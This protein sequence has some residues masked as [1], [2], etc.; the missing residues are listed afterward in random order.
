[1]KHGG[2]ENNRLI[3]CNL[4]Y[5]YQC[6]KAVNYCSVYYE[7]HGSIQNIGIND[8]F[9]GFAIG[10]FLHRVRRGDAKSITDENIQ[11]LCSYGLEM[12]KVSLQER[13]ARSHSMRIKNNT[14]CHEGIKNA[15]KLYMKNKG[16]DK[17][18]SPPTNYVDEN[19]YNLGS[20]VRLIRR[21]DHKQVHAWLEENGFSFKCNKD[22]SKHN[23]SI[24]GQNEK[25]FD[26]I[27]YHCHMFICLYNPKHISD[28]YDRNLPKV[29][30]TK[31]YPFSKKIRLLR[32][33]W[34]NEEKR[35]NMLPHIQKAFDELPHFFWNSEDANYEEFKT[36]LK[37]H[38]EHPKY[39]TTV[40]LPNYPKYP[41]GR[42]TFQWR[43]TFE[44]ARG[45][46]K[47]HDL[48]KECPYFILNAR[49]INNRN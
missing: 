48:M 16:T 17:I 43:K 20:T 2:F 8:I 40:D 32:N 25:V 14:Q 23:R 41:L 27:L 1:M 3:G 9:E 30:G 31:E 47:K 45:N 39:N 37:L 13:A 21:G 35:K 10:S 12:G 7:Q 11:K 29:I 6:N 38:G 26:D 5:E 33:H 18:G 28:W 19:G 46:K 24:T 22:E 42:K 36:A 49:Q 44:T 34:R 4:Y 15:F